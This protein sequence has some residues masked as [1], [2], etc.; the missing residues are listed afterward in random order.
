VD[1][2]PPVPHSTADLP[3]VGGTLRAEIDDFEV[4]EIP[5]YAPSGR[6]PHVYLWIE[7]RDLTTPEAIARLA[8]AGG[9][10]A[11]VVGWA[12]YKDRRAVTRQWISVEGVDADRARSLAA[13]GVR[14]LDVG[15]HDNRLRT[16]HLAG[17]RF[18]IVLRGATDEAGACAIA[19]RLTREGLANFFGE[20]RFGREGD[21]AA[22]AREFLLGGAPAPR[23]GRLRRLLASA[24][25]SELYNHALL[26]RLAAGGHSRALPGDLCVKHAT[27]G[28]F[29]ELD[30]A[31]LQPRLDA[32]E[33][34]I[35]GPLFGARMRWPEGEARAFEEALLGEELPDRAVLR[36]HRKL[37]PGGRRPY[38]LLPGPIAV[39]RHPAGLRAV[40]TLPPGAYATIVL[41][42]LC[43][44]DVAQGPAIG[45]DTGGPDDDAGHSPEETPPP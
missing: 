14:V 8:R 15:R 39:T 30:A 22:R 23:D 10:D 4:E 9:F 27:G 7:K 11:Q 19:D 37:L 26:R 21:N 1:P 36:A 44:T 16:G 32:Q 17:N 42:E 12:G 5:A 35:T 2:H 18:A 25:Q 40:F 41:R 33:V 29:Y 13:D 3:G 31:V 38:R 43:K 28:M 24:W 20:Q 34:S 6:G 45:Q